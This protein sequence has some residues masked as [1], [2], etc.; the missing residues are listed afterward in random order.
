MNISALISA[1]LLIEVGVIV[2]IKLLNMGKVSKLWY[3]EFGIVAV[4]CDVCSLL[5]GI[6]LANMLFPNSLLLGSVIVQV[7]HDILFYLFVIRPLPKGTNS[8]IDMMKTYASQESYT[9]IIGDSVM[10]ANTVLLYYVLKNQSIDLIV[11][12]GTLGLYAITYL[13]HT[14]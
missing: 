6:L 13:L 11:L 4:L 14:N 9:T 8:M 3:K 5:I 2:C 7:C 1:I 12:C 10:M